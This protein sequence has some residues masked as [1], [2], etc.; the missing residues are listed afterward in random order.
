MLRIG[1]FNAEVIN[2][3]QIDR[4]RAISRAIRWQS[5]L[6]REGPFFIISANASHI[7]AIRTRQANHGFF[8]VNPFAGMVVNEGPN[9]RNAIDDRFV[10]RRQHLD[11]RCER[12]IDKL[13]G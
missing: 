5:Q 1:S 2:K 12:S 3:I 13:N 4:V 10:G 8:E 11:F 9:F 7:S 6:Q